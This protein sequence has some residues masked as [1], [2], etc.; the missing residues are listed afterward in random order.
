MARLY[1]SE[2]EIHSL[3]NLPNFLVVPMTDWQTLEAHCTI[4]C[5]PGGWKPDA[6]RKQVDQI[7]SAS[8]HKI[9]REQLG[10]SFE[11]RPIELLTVGNGPRRVLMWTQMHGNEPTHTTALLN[12][13]NQLVNHADSDFAKTLTE[14][15]TLGIILAL[16]PDG[17]ER[18]TRHNAQ[19]ID[20][21][22]DALEFATYEGRVLRDVLKSF[23][24]DFGF[25]LHNQ[26]HRLSIGSPSE[27]VAVSLLVPPIDEANTQN[28]STRRAT[29]VAAT[30]CEKV[31]KQCGERISR[32]GIEYMARAFGEWVQRQG[33]SVILVEAGGWIDGS[34]DE[35]E[36]LHYAALSQTLEVIATDKLDEADAAS[37]TELPRFHDHL[38]FDVLIAKSRI[39]QSTKGKTTLAEIGIDFPS[40]ASGTPSSSFGVIGAVGDLHENGGIDMIDP[41]GCVVAPGRIVVGKDASVAADLGAT[42]LLVPVDLTDA[43][44]EIETKL[45]KL[46][47]Q[48][49]PIN[50]AL[51]VFSDALPKEAD[52][53]LMTLT[54]ASVHGLAAVIDRGDSPAVT[55]ACDRLAFPRIAS[56]EVPTT[57][58]PMPATLAD[59]VKETDSVAQQLGWADRGR[60]DLATAADFALVSAAE[61]TDRVDNLHQLVVGGTVTHH[62]GKV[63]CQE[64]GRW[65]V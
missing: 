11:G 33:V 64:A 39:A 8:D 19:G 31:R 41:S 57:E 35:L 13:L 18:N 60:I 58:D 17:A 26:R 46:S 20:I 59:W 49:M 22:R 48:S 21:N 6:I 42:T 47:S 36:V 65:L 2:Y 25:N 63:I 61:G 52:A 29:Q 15:L 1:S 53:V 55:E 27:P 43:P 24:P 50:S 62:E 34:F 38:V 40:R 5:P 56:S 54:L 16:N 12:L 44:A 3:F 28:D 30:F 23:Q 4:S 10:E 37:Y 14:G 9:Q 51:L 7:L 32:Y 45:A